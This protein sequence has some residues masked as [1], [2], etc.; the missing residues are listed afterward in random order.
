MAGIIYTGGHLYSNIDSSSYDLETLL[1]RLKAHDISSVVDL[2]SGVKDTIR[3]YAP[4]SLNELFKS[5]GVRYLSRIKDNFLFFSAFKSIANDKKKEFREQFHFDPL[6]DYL[7]S[8]VTGEG[9]SLLLFNYWQTLDVR[10]NPRSGNYM[11]TLN[12]KGAFLKHVHQNNLALSINHFVP[13][14]VFNT[15]RWLTYDNYSLF[16][17]GN[18]DLLN[19]HDT[20]LN[21]SMDDH[22]YHEDN[23][24]RYEEVSEGMEEWKD[25]MDESDGAVHWNID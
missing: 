8:T 24:V 23:E 6:V 4:S 12:L 5:K 15:D 11:H 2:R 17:I 18:G 9:N 3:D 7:N 21:K 14:S 20:I 19:L 13:I 25:M 1:K 10:I 22:S 16:E